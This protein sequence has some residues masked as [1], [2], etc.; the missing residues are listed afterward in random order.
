MNPNDFE[1]LL[2]V[3]R[4]MASKL[5]EERS[6]DVKIKLLGIL[7]SLTTSKKRRIQVE[8]IIIEAEVEGLSES[9]TLRLL[10]DLKKDNLISEPEEGFIKVL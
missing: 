1:E 5:A 10:D 2:K 7:E 9:E 6:F 8:H 3:Q 4:M